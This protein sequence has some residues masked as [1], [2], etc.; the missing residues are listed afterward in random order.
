MVKPTHK[1]KERQYGTTLT[2]G[3]SYPITSS[4]ATNAITATSATSANS[5]TSASYSLSSSYS[6]N[7]TTASYVVNSISSS[8]ALTA[9][10]AL[11]ASGGGTTLTTGS[12]YPITSSW[13]NN[14]ITASFAMN[15][16]SGGSGGT[17]QTGSIANQTVLYNVTTSQDNII[18][19]LNLSSNKWDVSVIEEWNSGSGDIYY[20]S[21]SL[22]MHFSGSNNSTTFT[23]SGPNSFTITSNNGAKITSS[24][25]KFGDTS[26]LFDGTGDNLSF[27]SNSQF[28]FGTGDFTIEMWIYPQSAVGYQCVM[29]IGTAAPYIFI[30]INA[31]STGTPFMWNDGNVI[32]GSQNFTINAWQHWSVVRNSGTVTMYLNGTNIG[33]ASFAGSLTDVT[34]TYIGTNS[35]GSQ[36]FVGYIDELRITKGVA[37][38]S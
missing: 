10:H 22:L 18:S 11:N 20:P 15:G 30:G 24:I 3:S 2:T 38:Y 17:V 14:A 19:G 36:G 21:S 1:P 8:Y 4:W 25:S 34:G 9:S 26:G 35:A 13:A 28:A 12:T 33:S 29:L 7:S 23:D 16:G 27:S 6:V 31:G 37:S 5:A 32:V